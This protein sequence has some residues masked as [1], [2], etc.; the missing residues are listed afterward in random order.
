MS[1]K[2]MLITVSI[3]LAAALIGGGTMAWFT[4]KADAPE[5]EFI[6]G[7][8]MIEAGTTYLYG[9]EFKEGDVGEVFEIYVDREN[10]EVTYA[11][12]W[13]SSKSSLNALA[14]DNNNHRLYYVDSPSDLF[15]YDLTT[16]TGD[17]DA[18]NL[19]DELGIS[20]K[21]YGA[22]YGLGAYWFI[23][24][25][26][27]NLWR[28]TFDPETGV[29]DEYELYHQNFAGGESFGFGDIAME[30]REGTIYASTSRGSY[31]TYNIYERE[32]TEFPD[33][34]AINLQLGY[35]GDGILYGHETREYTWYEVD[36]DTGIKTLFF[37]EGENGKMFSDLACS[38]QSN[39]NPGDS[40]T[41]RYRVTNTGTK[42]SYLK[43]ELETGWSLDVDYLQ[44]YWDELCFSETYGSIEELLEDIDTE[45][46]PVTLTLCQ[47]SQESW[48]HENGAFYY[49]EEVEPGGSVV[50]CLEVQ[51]GGENAGNAYQRAAY[52]VEAVAR[53]IQSSNNAVEEVEGWEPL[54]D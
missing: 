29:I 23:F 11:K 6:A 26:T 22:A 50:L 43:M 51:L 5:N 44:E 13:D 53:A 49:L 34:D 25:D 18:G 12:I 41:L 36:P 35:G 21:I 1:R 42:N 2:T 7:S 39:W 52:T 33:A 9:L 4:A 48:L 16:G 38:Y 10:N 40:E 14:H 32:Y 30:V 27:D 8:V 37:E 3:L 17:H 46:G 15:Y 24:E 54:R 28:V 19:K 31:F 45:E 20:R 47:S